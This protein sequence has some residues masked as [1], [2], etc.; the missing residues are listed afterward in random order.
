MVK[1]ISVFCDDGWFSFQRVK[2]TAS[3]GGREH[4]FE[5]VEGSPLRL[6]TFDTPDAINGNINMKT[7]QSEHWPLSV[8]D[9]R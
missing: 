2:S 1:D 6:Q 8:D 3:D 4:S 7:N 9:A 5:S